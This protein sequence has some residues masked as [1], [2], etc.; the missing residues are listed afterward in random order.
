VQYT[1]ASYAELALEAIPPAAL[2]PL[3]RLEAPQGVFPRGGAFLLEADDPARARMFDPA[4][5]RVGEWFSR[6]RQF[7]QAR[8]NLQ[9]LYT[10]ATLLALSALFLL[11]GRGP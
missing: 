6:L 10:L 4:F 7:Q 8:L 3:V 2:Q 5:R 9:L 1:A 11:H